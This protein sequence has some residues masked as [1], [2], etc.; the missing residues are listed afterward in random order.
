MSVHP[1]PVKPTREDATEALWRTYQA[2]AARAQKSLRLDD[3]VM[4]GKAWAKFIEAFEH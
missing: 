3:G 1:L 2:A 4:A